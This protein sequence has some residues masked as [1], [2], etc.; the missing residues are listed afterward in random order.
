MEGG[1]VAQIIINEQTL[2]KTFI[3]YQ[4]NSYKINNEKT[5]NRSCVFCCDAHF[6][7][8]K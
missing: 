3:I 6:C 4:K 5:I 1:K 8:E 7:A 2:T